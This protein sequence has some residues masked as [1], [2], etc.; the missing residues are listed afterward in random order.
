[1]RTQRR[2]SF[3]SG[4][5]DPVLCFESVLTVTAT[6]LA[7]DC[8]CRKAIREDLFAPRN[9]YP[10][11]LAAISRAANSINQKAALVIAPHVAWSPP[12]DFPHIRYGIVSRLRATDR[13]IDR[14]ARALL[15][16]HL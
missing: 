4:A 10:F 1:M 8:K 11:M 16:Q 12:Y 9:Q 13:R 6:H 3:I 14:Y 15:M 5:R 7:C 2:R